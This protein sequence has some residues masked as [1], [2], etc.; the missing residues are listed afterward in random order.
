[1]KSQKKESR[2]IFFFRMNQ[3]FC[4]LIL[5]NKLFKNKKFWALLKAK[6]KKKLIKIQKT[7]KM[8]KNR[9]LILKKHFIYK[10]HINFLNYQEIKNQIKNR[11]RFKQINKQI[12][13]QIF[14][15]IGQKEEYFQID[16]PKNSKLKNYLKSRN[17]RLF[18]KITTL[19][20]VIQVVHM[21]KKR[22]LVKKLLQDIMESKEF[23]KFFNGEM[24]SH[25]L[26]KNFKNKRNIHLCEKKFK[27]SN[28]K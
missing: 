17:L 7:C 6:M 26:K 18:F 16:R 28:L 15:N 21:Q 24:R 25:N 19:I 20:Y 10:K 9:F 23:A 27:N 11:K 4:F 1:M 14:K 2:I 5:E 3:R 8:I 22:N 13:M 12:K